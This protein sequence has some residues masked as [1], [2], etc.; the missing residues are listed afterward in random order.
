MQHILIVKQIKF[1][2]LNNN[3]NYASVC[4]YIIVDKFICIESYYSITITILCA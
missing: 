4:L 2:R 3:I 1:L